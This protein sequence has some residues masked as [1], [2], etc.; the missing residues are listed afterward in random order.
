MGFIE[1]ADVRYDLSGGWT[2]F[3]GVSFRVPDGGHAALVGANGIG[4]STL[5]RLVAGIEAPAAGV[6]RADGRV[7]MMRQFIGSDDRPTTVRDFLLAYSDRDVAEAAA[8]LKSAEDRLAASDADE[9][10]QLAYAHA[11]AG[12]EDSGGY[13]AEVLWDRCTLA[14]FGQGYPECAGRLIESLSGGERKRLAL[15]VIFGSPFDVI[16]LDEPDNAL[17]IEGKTWLEETISECSKTILFVSHDRTVLARTATRIVTLEGRAAWTHPGGYATYA[18]AREARLDRIDE[19][20]RRY[21][22]KHDHLEANLKELKRR[23]AISDGFASL[24]RSAE[25]KLA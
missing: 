20:H 11:L 24:A 12:W 17:D 18:E 4:K 6:V 1:L 15:E 21:R 8:R 10:V 3:E 7:G 22:E 16:L 2:L 25:K 14:A 23:A 19:E 9:R 5:L 13:R